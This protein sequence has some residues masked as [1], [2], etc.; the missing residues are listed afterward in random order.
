MEEKKQTVPITEWANADQPREKLLEK[1]KGILT[2]AELIGILIGSGSKT[3]TAVELARRI[4]SSVG[5]DLNALGK[6]NVAQLC[7][8]KGIGEAKAI[9]II[10]AL[11]LGK[12]M[13]VLE[14]PQRIRI[15]N[16][17]LV[18]EAIR[19]EI[20]DLLHEEFWVLYLD[21]SNHIIRKSNISKGGVSG[22]VVDARII[23]KQAIE[24]LA[25]SIVLC[26]NHPSGNLK[27]SEEDIRITKKLKDAGKLVDIAIIDH[28]IIAGNN[29]FS[30]ADEG[31]L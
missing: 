29:F 24:N 8:F 11:E 21:R 9:S 30:F 5:N 26:H 14:S 31:L 18:F 20:G 15:I 10:A 7:T 28:I 16:S 19:N 3:E 12:R 1:G 4:L 2:D 22:T 6:L 17:K 25:S 23:F 27:P 13:K